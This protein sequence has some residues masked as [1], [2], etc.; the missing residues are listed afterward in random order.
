ME[1]R[2]GPE[3]VRRLFLAGV[4]VIVPL[5]ATFIVLRFLFRSLDGLLGP[6]LQHLIGHE[7]P[8][9]GIVATLVLIFLAGFLTSNLVG[10][11]LY[12]IAELFFIRAP[13]VRTVYSAAK[14]FVEAIAVPSKRQFE[15]VV[16]V[17]YPRAGS[18]ALGF[19]SKSIAL[20]GFP[21]RDKLVAVF[22]PSTP[23]PFTGFAVLLPPDEIIPLDLSLEEG[24][25][26]IVSGG[27][28]SPETFNVKLPPERNALPHA[29][30]RPA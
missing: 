23:T 12:G 6:P 18:Y 3:K 26:F 10:S 25:K 17:Q 27:I 7:I 28:A 4:L 30:S 20:T 13:I 11:R 21:G 8:G 9:I 16:L 1:K 5:I 22:V 2:R 14:Q 29:I 24:V 19:V 15:R